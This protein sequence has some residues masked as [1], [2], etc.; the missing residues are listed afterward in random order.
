MSPYVKKK[1]RRKW[2]GGLWCFFPSPAG[3]AGLLRP[4]KGDRLAA[5]EALRL[6]LT[7]K[8]TPSA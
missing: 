4:V 8:F 6:G 3:S 7:A 5:F 2:P 1:I